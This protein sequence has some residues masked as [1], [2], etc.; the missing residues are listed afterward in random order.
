MPY[1]AGASA[2]LSILGGIASANGASSAAYNQSAAYSFNAKIQQQQEA[3]FE[4]QRQ[5]VYANARSNADDVRKKNAAQM[6]QIR[7][8]YGASGLTMDGSPLDVLASVAQEGELDVSKTLYKGEVEG[9]M[10]ADKRN[11]AHVS[12]DLDMW[13]A[14]NAMEAGTYSSAAA[15]IGGVSGAMRSISGFSGWGGGRGGGAAP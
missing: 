15:L 6:G 10:L 4:Q 11:M 14:K 3:A 7:T 9:A 13:Y 12:S 5:L 8:A 1:M 2:G